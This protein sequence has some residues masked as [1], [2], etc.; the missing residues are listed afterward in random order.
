MANSTYFSHYG[1]NAISA[2]GRPLLNAVRGLPQHL[3]DALMEAQVRQ[4]EREI[5]RYIESTGGKLTDSVEREI[6][7]RLLPRASNRLF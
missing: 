4:T 1:T 5:A 6:E 3:L 7:E 2:V